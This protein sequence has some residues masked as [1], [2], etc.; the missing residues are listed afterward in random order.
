MNREQRDNCEKVANVLMGLPNYQCRMD[1]WASDME[2]SGGTLILPE[3]DKRGKPD[4][5]TAACMAGWAVTVLTPAL[6]MWGSVVVL[7]CEWAEARHLTRREYYDDVQD[8]MPTA[9]YAI[10]E[11]GSH[12]LGGQAA[13]YF[14][15][16]E[17]AAKDGLTDREWMIVK[18]KSVV[19]D[20]DAGVF[21]TP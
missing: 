21:G 6:R 9:G 18:L 16:T 14:L 15:H 7:P 19:R 8:P 20:Y 10:P 1:H 13:Y 4:C 5:G 17:A 2:L 3:P 11:V 12:L